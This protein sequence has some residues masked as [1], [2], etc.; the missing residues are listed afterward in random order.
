M[1]LCLGLTK[2]PTTGTN[3]VSVK[4]AIPIII[5]V[6]SEEAPLPMAYRGMHNSTNNYTQYQVSLNAILFFT[7]LQITQEKSQVTDEYHA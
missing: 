2:Y 7:L 3:I 1:L 6:S 5:P 4:D